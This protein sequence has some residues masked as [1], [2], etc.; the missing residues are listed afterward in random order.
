MELT[1]RLY[2]HDSPAG[3]THSPV[4]SETLRIPNITPGLPADHSGERRPV[5]LY[6]EHFRPNKSYFCDRPPFP[7]KGG[8][9]DD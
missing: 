7:Y 9:A 5:K 3:T 1:R 8:P 2:N 4:K 6:E